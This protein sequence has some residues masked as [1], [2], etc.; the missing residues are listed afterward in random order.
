[1]ANGISGLFEAWFAHLSFPPGSKSKQTTRRPNRSSLP[2]FSSVEGDTPV[3]WLRVAVG[4]LAVCEGA[5]PVLAQTAIPAPAFSFERPS[6][7]E[8]SVVD[9]LEFIGLRHIS[10]AAVAAQL[11]L[12]P[13]DRFDAAKLRNDLRTLGRLGWFSSIRV[14]EVSRTARNSPI[15]T[16]QE[17]LTLV[18][19][20]KEE[21]VLSRVEYSG[22]RLL[23]KSQIEKLL[24]EKKLTP[25]LGKPGD[26]AALHQIALAIRTVL[27]ELGH[28]EALVQMRQEMKA[29]ATLNVRFEIVDGPHLPVRQV[30]F[31]GH[32]G[33]SEKLLRAQMQ[34]IAPWK[35][36]ASLRS[37]NAYTQSAFEEDRRRILNYFQ[38]HGYPEARV[39]NARVDKIAEHAHKW[40]LF[41]HSAIQPGLLLTI[42]VDGGP[43]YRFE[44]I[45]TTQTL[46]QAIATR[47]ER[48]LALPVTEQGR[49]F[50]L[51]DVD[52]LRR[53][54]TARLRS[55]DLK[56]DT[57]S[58]QTVEARPIFD[59]DRHSVRLKLNL[60]DS[61]PYLVHRL[62]FQGLHKFNDR[63]VRRRIPLGEGHPLDEHALEIGLSKLARTGYF[64]PIRKEDIHIQLD[65]I[66]H[67]A[68]VTIRLQEIGQQR[69]TLDGGRAQF[70]STLGIAYTLFD[71]LNHEELLSAKLDG[72][73]ESLQ[74]LLGIAKEG[75]FGTRGSLAFSIFDNVIR[76]RF[77]HG[78]QGPFTTSHSEGINVPW[79]YAL[80]NSDSI[81]VSYSL[82]RAVSDQTFGAASSAT[83]V[84]PIDLR[85]HTSSRSLGTAW[86]HD[87][88]NEHFF[89]SDSASGSFL[90]GDENMLHSSGEAARIF[91]DPVLSP[92]NAW[93]FRT[94]FS[95]AGSY[96]G[97]APLYSRFFA[98]DQFVR[99][100]RDGEL[101]PVAMTE[102]ATPSG[103]IVPSPS[104]AGANLITAA[105]AEYRI[106]IRDGVQAT[107]FFDLG[108][109]WLLPN[110][111]G[112]AK[113]TLLSTTNGVLHG[114][115][116][117]QLQWTIPG[118]QVPFRS[119]YSFNVLRLDRLVR[120]SEKSLLH[121]HN[122]FGA[123]GWGLGSLF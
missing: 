65:D 62:E 115:T 19:Y 103:V 11:S 112:P 44:T 118:I 43:F 94:T 25:G 2:W 69:L 113:P 27:N 9:S 119:Y 6:A 109:G 32:P 122:R 1:V 7:K 8:T 110:W 107:G 50:S 67:T 98:G 95:A 123:F 82:T 74:L 49:A 30:R 111:L 35:P 20:F 34:N 17:G 86:A 71:L 121:A 31:E 40:V 91:R 92:M 26:P 47:R 104:Y 105:N 48:P 79:T 38:D 108:S 55:G 53:F 51:Q 13:G 77:T 100:L 29:H 14:Q 66:R 68:D 23:S 102:R 58:F 10:S 89:L 24:E 83:G 59:P 12:H 80:T 93:A 52:K 90:G 106:P 84:P 5:V 72:G 85:T 96:R 87:T 39:G 3:H 28:P 4:L 75:I 116:G 73:P 117:I 46:Q 36:L 56:S 21:P 37:K 97:S 57:S 120:L 33:V 114:S 42:P 63:F 41:A 101:G 45:D 64:K 60:S 88:G 78:V 22:S 99:G 54:Y 15:P 61:P 18:L 70:G 81:G 16:P 76:P